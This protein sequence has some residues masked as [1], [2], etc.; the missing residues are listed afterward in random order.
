[1]SIAPKNHLES[2]SLNESQ[3]NANQLEKQSRLEKI[4]RDLNLRVETTFKSAQENDRTPIL[5]WHM[6]SNSDF[7]RYYIS[8]KEKTGCEVVFVPQIAIESFGVHKKVQV[9]V[10]RTIIYCNNKTSSKS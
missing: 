4:A 5:Q 10:T 9:V 8:E 6:E 2:Q 7:L 1:M 3:V